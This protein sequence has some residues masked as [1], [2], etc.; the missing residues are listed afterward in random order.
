[1]GYLCGGLQAAYLAWDGVS[2][3]SFLAIVAMA[4]VWCSDILFLRDFDFE[5]A[6]RRIAEYES[7]AD[8]AEQRAPTRTSFEKEEEDG[9]A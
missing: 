9:W 2:R 6:H 8:S 5:A 7:R 4:L 1:L 3:L